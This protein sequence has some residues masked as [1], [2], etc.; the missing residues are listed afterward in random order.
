MQIVLLAAALI[1]VVFTRQWSTTIVLVVL[2]VFNALLGLRGESKAEASLAALTKMMKNIARVRRDG[3]GHRIDAE[4][5]VPG[6]V[7]LVE[8]GDRLPADG[9]LF[10]TATLEIEEAA[11]TGESVAFVQGQ[12]GDRQTRSAAGRPP[13]HGLHEHLGHARSRR[14]D[15]HHHRHGH[16]DGPHRRPAQQDRVRQDAAAEAGSTR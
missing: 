13:Q 5:M 6:D 15:R 12:C 14:A 4:Q 8:A 9:R 7:V 16:G 10:V 1:S 2:T 11:L 3:A